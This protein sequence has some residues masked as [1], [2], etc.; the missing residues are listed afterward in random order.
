MIETNTKLLEQILE[1]RFY[2]E[3][4]ENYD[5]LKKFLGHPNF[6]D[7]EREFKKQLATAILQSAV[8]PKRYEKLTNH[9][10][11]TQEEVNELLK[12]EIW[13]P[14]YGDEPITMA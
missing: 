7:R 3:A 12:I 5:S 9:E 1:S 6:P 8:S 13:Q 10:L 11:E 14:L 2:A 4:V